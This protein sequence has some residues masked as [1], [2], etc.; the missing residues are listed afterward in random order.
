M[1][2]SQG[3]NSCE[4][5][6]IAIQ[7]R[8]VPGSAV[9]SR[10][11]GPSVCHPL[12]RCPPSGRDDVDRLYEL[13]ADL[14]QRVG[15][16]RLLREC[17][18]ATGWPSRGVYFFFESGEDRDSGEPRIVRVG[19]H[20]V[21]TGSNTTFWNRLSAHRGVLGG[22]RAGG[23]NHRG[24]IFRL[25]VG[26]ALIA[27]DGIDSPG[28]RIWGIGSSAKPEVCAVEYDIERR[29]SDYIGAMPLLWIEVADEA[30]TTSARKLIEVKTIALLSNFD[31][32]IVD[33][34]SPDWLGRYSPHPA[35]SRS[36]LWNVHH[37]DEHHDASF[38]D[39]LQRYVR[40]MP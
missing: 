32:E 21:S 19:T 40:A 5:C 31:R 30:G 26:R 6:S 9:H 12:R 13:V 33:A 15:D 35:V 37:V 39:V 38:F 18:K 14:R 36:G 1:L 10:G 16:A 23:G 11:A 25:H 22:S 29:V 4:A 27:R 20:G 24:S 3:W 34:A 28:A 7:V 17:S 8:D 2:K